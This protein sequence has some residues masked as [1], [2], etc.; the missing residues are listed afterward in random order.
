MNKIL[1]RPINLKNIYKASTKCYSVSGKLPKK[2]IQLPDQADVVII[3]E[4]N[5]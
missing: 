3:G 2:P 4:L 1:H 5:G